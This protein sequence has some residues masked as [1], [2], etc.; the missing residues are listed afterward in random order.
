MILFSI[1][2][3]CYCEESLL[4]V[5]NGIGSLQVAG[6]VLELDIIF[7]L[8]PVKLSCQTCSYLDTTCSWPDISIKIPWSVVFFFSL[9]SYRT[10]VMSNLIKNL[11]FWIK[12]SIRS[13]TWE[14]SRHLVTLPLVSPRNDVWETC[15]EIPYWWR[16]TTQIWVV[17]LIGWIKFPTWHDQSEAVPRSG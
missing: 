7:R 16:G 3:L 8:A 2:F 11:K 14:N 6:Q 1:H 15:W 17:L 13:V 10:P 9:F 4:P 5:I 12:S